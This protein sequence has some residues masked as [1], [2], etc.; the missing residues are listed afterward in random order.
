MQGRRGE[1]NLRFFP[2]SFNLLYTSGS[3]DIVDRFIS[4]CCL[5]E[6]FHARGTCSVSTVTILISPKLSKLQ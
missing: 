2:A 1:S 3:K 6:T 5:D 4:G